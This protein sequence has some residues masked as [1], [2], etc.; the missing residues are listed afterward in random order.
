MLPELSFSDRWS[1]GTNLWERDWSN[2]GSPRFTDFPLLCACSESSLTNLIGS[3]L[4][5]L[6]LQSHSKQNQNVVIF[7]A[8]QKDRGLWGREWAR[9]SLDKNS[10]HAFGSAAAE[11]LLILAELQGIIFLVFRKLLRTAGNRSSS[12]PD[13]LSYPDNLNHSHQITQSEKMLIIA[14]R[15]NGVGNCIRLLTSLPQ[16]GTEE[17]L[18]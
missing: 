18:P 6:C 10:A 9:S 15:G 1:R 7:S 2:S 17:Q 8:D 12:L 16:V 5:L 14:T 3:G 13:R 4:N 11:C